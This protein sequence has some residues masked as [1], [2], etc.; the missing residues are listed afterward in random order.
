MAYKQ[1]YRLSWDGET[2]SECEV[3]IYEEGYTGEVLTLRQGAAPVL[4]MDDGE[5][6]RG[7]SLELTLEAV[8]DGQLAG[9]YTTDNRRYRVDLYRNRLLI[10]Q[11]F[12]LPELYAEPCVAPPYD[13][14][15][16]AAD[17]L[18]ILKNNK[19]WMTSGGVKKLSE[20]VH[21]ILFQT[22]L[23]MQISVAD[24]LRRGG[25]QADRTMLVQTEVNVAMFEGMTFYEALETILTS[26]GAYVTQRDGWWRIVRYTDQ[27]ASR[28][29]L[30]SSQPAR[31]D[32]HTVTIGCVGDDTYPL[33]GSLDMEIEPAR[34][35]LKMENPYEF[36]PSMLENWNFEKGMEGWTTSGSVERRMWEDSYYV[37]INRGEY[38]VGIYPFIRNSVQL[39]NVERQLSISFEY[40]VCHSNIEDNPLGPSE[41]R[42][43]LVV[44]FD[45]SNG[46][47]YLTREGWQ[48]EE[49]EIIIKTQEQTGKVYGVGVSRFR[50]PDQFDKFTI[51]LENVPWSGIL[52]INIINPYRLEHP[53]VSDNINLA[54]ENA[55]YVRNVVVQHN[56]EQNPDTEL[57]MNPAASKDD[58]VLKVAFVDAP[59]HENAGKTFL[60]V[61]KFGSGYMGKW[62]CNGLKGEDTFGNVALQCRAGQTGVAKMLLRGTIR[63]QM[64]DLY[65]DKYSGTVM[66]LREYA[67][68]LVE[69]EMDVTLCEVRGVINAEGLVRRGPRVASVNGRKVVR[70]SSSTSHRVYNTAGSTQTTPKMIRDLGKARE[71]TEA[72]WLEVDD[73]LGG[74]T[75]KATLADLLQPAWKKSELVHDG[76]YLLVDGQKIKAGDSDAW[77]G[78]RTADWMDQPVRK[79]DGVTF[80]E[81][82][83]SEVMK[84]LGAIDSM[85]AGKGI[86]MDAE[87]GLV[88]ADRFEA[89]HSMTVMELIINRLS[90]MEG[91]YSFSDG[92]TV[93]RLERQEDGTY[94]LWL[95]KRWEHDFTALHINDIVYGMINTLAAGGTD[96][97]TSWMRVLHVDT[98]ANTVDVT[99]YPDTEVPGGKNYP[100][101]ELMVITRRG[102]PVDPERQG[103]WYLSSSEHCICM[104]DGVTKPILEEANYSVIVGRL[105]HLSI[106]DNLP[107]NYR[108]S[109][110]YCRGIATQDMMQID[111][112]GTPVRSENNRGKWSVAEATN[113]PYESSLSSYDA[114]Y[115][116]GCK[117]MC[118]KT[119]T[120][121]E[122][123]FG[124]TDWAMIEG[125]PDFSID[126]ESSR[127]WYFDADRLDTTFRVVG[128]LYNRDVTE[129][130]LDADIT[131]TRDTGNPTEDNAWAM[132]H[133]EA[134]KELHLTTADLGPDYMNQIA[135]SFTATALLR[136]GQNERMTSIT[137]NII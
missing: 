40:A 35:M 55:V 68:D 27:T 113:R 135:C 131:W 30:N 59:F 114:V 2:G 104:L 56:V 84:T 16:T 62:T 7:T 10:W 34:K 69:D 57:E 81:V 54:Y 64:G 87:R 72:H 102:N 99:L 117:W 111:Y 38:K 108:Q 31:W 123:R 93:D 44:V 21:W 8:A 29:T 70:A 105:K 125:N 47:Y 115:H 127:G 42:V 74:D 76:G 13:V 71:V 112:E 36:L 130:I 66:Y 80:R 85:T 90:A 98:A 1:K 92:G 103:Y 119:G 97:H 91:D 28:E 101:S 75:K 129:H 14:S 96:Y 4:R 83:V 11:G 48:Q 106:F 116:Y 37:R 110:V 52:T 137:K 78:R 49:G 88:Q 24:T 121:Q 58:S 89:R 63:A 86:V 60:N 41:K 132:A 61:L 73:G 82:V 45:G 32:P 77:E 107:I 124:C 5:A 50:Y 15:V 26:I 134:G 120:T 17:G 136:D 94:R 122:P 22:G 6:I 12:T 100:P 9:F 79:G 43:K 67:W 118:L 18:G 39:D 128:E 19:F 65:R 95:R 3:R 23:S 46:K 109:Y 33:G 51:N 133:A 25:Q 126:I 20:V 53:G